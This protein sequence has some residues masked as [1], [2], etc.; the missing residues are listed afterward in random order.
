MLVRIQ[1][2]N[3]ANVHSVRVIRKFDSLGSLAHLSRYLMAMRL[4]HFDSYGIFRS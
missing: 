1:I 4:S 2:G 3:I